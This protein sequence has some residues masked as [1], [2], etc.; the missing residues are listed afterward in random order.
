MKLKK[1]MAGSLLALFALAACT[2]D[3]IVDTGMEET[4]KGVLTLSMEGVALDASK[5]AQTRAEQIA[6]QEENEIQS[7]ILLVYGL[8]VDETGNYVETG[9][10]CKVFEYRK[11]WGAETPG[12]NVTK[13][14]L[15]QTGTVVTGKMDVTA[16]TQSK[17]AVRALVNGMGVQMDGADAVLTAAEMAATPFATQYEWKEYVG[18]NGWRMVWG[19][20][21]DVTAKIET[22]LPM[23]GNASIY[24]T[25]INNMNLSLYREVARFDLRNGRTDLRIGSITPMQACSSIFGYSGERKDMAT[26]SL[27]PTGIDPGMEWENVPAEVAPG[28]YTYPS[29]KED[30]KQPM[31][32]KVAAKVNIGG[33]WTDKTYKMFLQK[34]GA[35]IYV[36]RNTRYVINIQDI[37]DDIITATIRIENWT[38]GETIDG[39]INGDATDSKKVP[40][41]VTATADD[42]ANGVT[43]QNAPLNG[44]PAKAT[45]AEISAGKYLRFTTPVAKAIT[46]AVGD[47]E[48]EVQV[49]IISSSGNQANVWL[50]H[51]A[52]AGSGTDAGK[53]V[54]T[55]TVDVSGLLVP[56]VVDMYV[57][58]KN[59]TYPDKYIMFMVTGDAIMLTP[60]FNGRPSTSLEADVYVADGSAESEAANTQHSLADGVNLCADGWML[61]AKSDLIYLAGVTGTPPDY[62]PYEEVTKPNFIDA[63]PVGL[64]WSST[65]VDAT[66]GW[67]MQVQIGPSG[68][69]EVGFFKGID[70]TNSNR[71][72]CVKAPVPTY[73]DRTS[74][75]VGG[76]FVV[77][78]SASHEAA[79]TQHSLADGNTLCA[80]GWRLPTK[81]DLVKLAGIT[82]TPPD[83]YPYEEV[84]KSNFIDAFPV[85]MYWSGTMA[86]ATKGWYM[87]VQIGPS[88]KPEVGFFKGIEATNS[89][90][91]RCVKETIF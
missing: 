58:V 5:L 51:T 32:F 44:V 82:G 3:S 42:A 63:F 27:L 33:V 40:T 52:V 91:I 16:L 45:F 60:P 17:M 53:T 64:Y 13:L 48:P 6:T 72:R 75:A 56:A 37:T 8:N 7:M 84:T 29:S 30:E 49:D 1:Y 66:K 86:D 38:E 20:R 80:T 54:H 89:N 81:E 76:S 14:E 19:T 34:D 35:D 47:D 79:N 22:P 9:G 21:T 85:G 88:G 39:G 87:Q 12:T 67:Y 31:Y 55:L 4:G 46:R 62:Y 10:A 41:V 83:Y 78:G 18:G 77:D 70:A 68:K 61:P 90:R 73:N 15:V 11:D 74:V 23:S 59:K 43:W 57:R 65:M 50:K 2:N 25:G 28:F 26:V 24:H 69:P 36:N 71:I